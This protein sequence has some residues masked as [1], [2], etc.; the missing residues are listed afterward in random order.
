MSWCCNVT[1]LAATVNCLTGLGE[2]PITSTMGEHSVSFTLPSLS[3]ERKRDGGGN[4]QEEIR[5]QEREKRGRG[6]DDECRRHSHRKGHRKS[7]SEQGIKAW[8]WEGGGRHKE[9]VRPA[10]GEG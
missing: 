6:R 3:P 1:G 4:K 8:E 5:R 9:R 7:P 10:E 2:D